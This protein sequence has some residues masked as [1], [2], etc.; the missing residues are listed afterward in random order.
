VLAHELA[1]VRRRDPLVAMLAR[2]NRCLFWFHPLAWWLEKRLALTA[3]HAADDAA[4]RV[5]SEKRKYAEVLLDM[6]ETVRRRGG[7]FAWEGVGVDNPGLLGERIERILRG[8]VSPEVSRIR[9][10]IVGFCCALAIFLAAACS[11]QR[12]GLVDDPEIKAQ[13]AN[14]GPELFS[15]IRDLN[16]AQVQELEFAVQSNPDDWHT[17]AKLAMYYAMRGAK[18]MGVEKTVAARRPHVLWLIEHHPEV[19]PGQNTMIYPGPPDPLADP[20]GYAA[21]KA[22]WLAQAARPGVSTAVLR[23]AAAFL[24]VADRPIAED[25]QIRARAADPAGSANYLGS[26]YARVL[27][28]F[29]GHSRLRMASQQTTLAETPYALQIRAKLANS[30]DAELLLATGRSLDYSPRSTEAVS[31]LAKSYVERALSMNNASSSARRILA[32]RIYEQH[33]LKMWQ[34]C[35]TLT[36]SMNCPAVYTL[37]ESDQLS[38]LPIMAAMAQDRAD[39]DV[40]VMGSAT[41][42]PD[43]RMVQHPPSQEAVRRGESRA[44]A[45][46][47]R[48][49]EYARAAL[50]VASRFSGDPDCGTTIYTAN[51]VLGL[52]SLHN[53]DAK[54]AQKFLLAASEAPASE[55]LAYWYSNLTYRLPSRLLR[56]GEGGFV[57]YLERFAGLKP[58]NREL[59]DSVVT[60]F[61]RMAKI[62]TQDPEMSRSADL[63]RRGLRPEWYFKN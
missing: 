17:R 41:K 4:L 10:I 36:T 39:M 54:A 18:E 22:L 1:H 48:A 27:T 30:T 23:N 49:G 2:L 12:D 43:G 13:L 50:Q 37:P 60:Y 59:A 38:V 28:G 47:E 31:A 16:Q 5:S 57:P 62:R 35:P 46:W 21:G 42:A 19:G 7:R 34:T 15:E 55:Q 24:E 6:A 56:S 53:G 40:K 58:S 33:R 20:E 3:E 51:M 8:W 11:T 26:F 14:S 32:G 29:D 9:K 63:I 61:E 44:A 52:L 25:L 45:D